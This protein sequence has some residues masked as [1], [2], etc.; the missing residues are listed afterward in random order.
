MNEMETTVYPSNMM[1]NIV[2]ILFIVLSI[3]TILLSCPI[4]ILFNQMMRILRH[5]HIIGIFT[6]LCNNI[7]IIQCCQRLQYGED[8]CRNSV[9]H[10]AAMNNIVPFVSLQSKSCNQSF[11]SLAIL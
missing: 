2:A 8:Y 1:N 4:T 10:V 9:H 11:L 6:M 3:L 5:R 7:V